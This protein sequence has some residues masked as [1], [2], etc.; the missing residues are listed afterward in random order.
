MKE[1]GSGDFYSV[2]LDGTAHGEACNL[3]GWAEDRIKTHPGDWRAERILE[4]WKSYEE[5][6]FQNLDYVRGLADEIGAL[7]ETDDEEAACA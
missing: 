2:T 1:R 4:A 6:G 3:R 7:G 5:S